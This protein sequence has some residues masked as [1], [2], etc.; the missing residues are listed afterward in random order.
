MSFIIMANISITEVPA[1]G[2]VGRPS[3][4]SQGHRRRVGRAENC[5]FYD[6]KNNRGKIRSKQRGHACPFV[7]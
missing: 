1:L 3:S 5:S 7:Y 2:T 6:L 4:T